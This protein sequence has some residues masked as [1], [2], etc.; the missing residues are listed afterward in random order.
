MKICQNKAK[1]KIKIKFRK[2]IILCAG[3]ENIP[4]IRSGR[5]SNLVIKAKHLWF[6]KQKALIW[7]I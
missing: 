6:W 5:F 3:R 4:V 1:R 7:L 2:L